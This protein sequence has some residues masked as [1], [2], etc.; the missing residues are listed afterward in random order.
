MRTRNFWLLF[1]HGGASLLV[2]VLVFVAA[3]VGGLVALAAPAVANPR[4]STT[5]YVAN[6]NDDTVAVFDIATNTVT[7]TVSVGNGP[8]FVAATPDG[9]RVYVPNQLSNTVSVIDT[10]TNTVS[11]TIGVGTTPI[12]AL[13]NPAGTLVYVTNQVS[14]PSR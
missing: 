12:S 2:A 1:G 5:A 7:A 3:F 4:G 11:T 9:A 13:V 14:T 6:F 8:R 10:A